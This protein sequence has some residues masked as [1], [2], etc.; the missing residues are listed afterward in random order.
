MTTACKPPLPL[1][2][3]EGGVRGC[4]RL[5]K[6]H[7][8]TPT[9]QC[10]AC[11]RRRKLSYLA[12]A[13]VFLRVCICGGCSFSTASR[14][15]RPR[16]AAAA[17]PRPAPSST[18]R[19]PR[20]AAWCICWKSGSA[21]RC[22]S[23]RPTSW[24]LTAAGRAYQSGLTPI[25]DALASLTAQVTAPSSVRVLT[26]G[27]GPTFAMSWLI[28]RLADFRKAGARHRRAHHHRRR[29]GA[30]RRRLELRRQARRRRL[31]GPGRRA[32]VRRRPDA[33]LRAAA[34][35][36]AEA[37]GRP[38]RA[39]PAA[40]RAFARRLAALAE[41]RRRRRAS[42]RADRNSSS[43]ARRCRPPSTGSASPWASGPIST[44][45]SPP[46]GWSRRSR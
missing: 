15:S 34:R 26:I 46:A 41:G 37:P 7:E 25:F 27:V 23:A 2:R 3:G 33:G 24:S 36:R 38:Q 6:Q 30:V 8:F 31:A 40:R 39:E 13:S 9:F 12:L 10:L 19:R 29:R 35:H 22:S 43:T 21:S 44:T 11:R 20:S 42:P 18:S 17:L 32:A 28:P 45:T 16:R 1:L 14:H 5:R 4:T